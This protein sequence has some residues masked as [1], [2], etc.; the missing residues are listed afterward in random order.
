MWFTQRWSSS[1]RG[2]SSANFGLMFDIDGVLVRG[3]KVLPFAPKAFQKL[4][5]PSTKSF[6][7]P[8]V[9]VTNAGN[10]LRQ[11]KARQLSDWLGVNVSEDQVIMSHSPLKMFNK[12]HDKHVLVSGQGP[13]DEI[14]RHLGFG[15]ITTINQLKNAFPLLDYVDCKRRSPV[16]CSFERFFPPIEAILLLGE[17]IRWETSLQLTLDVLLTDGHPSFLNNEIRYPHIPVLA[18]NMDLQW[19]AEA[20]LPRFGHGAYILCLENLYKKI[21]GLDLKYTALVGKPSE[22]TYRHGESV[23]QEEA[24]KCGRLQPIEHIYFIGDNICTDIYGANLYNHHLLKRR[25][26]QKRVSIVENNLRTRS[27]DLLLGDEDLGATN[28]F[29]VLVETGVYSSDRDNIVT[30]QHSPR[31]FLPV[32]DSYRLPTLVAKNVLEAIE[33]IFER[34]EFE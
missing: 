9:F 24:H 15:R 29:S 26:C 16:P 11:T 7:V 2:S 20:P 10:S 12:Y 25:K 14:A 28:C 6:I 23:L 3:K 8:T 4:I 21:T 13:V 5:D 33:L 17:P 31:D 18:C 30:L 22:I 1:F 34:E 27:M 32:E 19:M